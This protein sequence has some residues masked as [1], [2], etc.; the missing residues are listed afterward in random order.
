MVRIIASKL[1]STTKVAITNMA[2]EKP[3]ISS[4]GGRPS[5]YI[6]IKKEK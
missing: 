6:T 2:K 3:M 5:L 4:A 1:G